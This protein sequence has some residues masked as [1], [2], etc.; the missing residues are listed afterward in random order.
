M[1]VL[2]RDLAAAKAMT[3]GAGIP[4]VGDAGL[5]ERLDAALAPRAGTCAR[6]RLPHTGGAESAAEPGKGDDLGPV[7]PGRLALRPAD[8]EAGS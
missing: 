2:E 3:C 4:P 7:T 5:W 8:V 6:R 1:S